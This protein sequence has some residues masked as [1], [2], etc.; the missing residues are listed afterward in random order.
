MARKAAQTN[1]QVE[2]TTDTLWHRRAAQ[3]N[4]QVEILPDNLV[5]DTASVSDSVVSVHLAGR[6][7]DN[8][9]VHDSVDRKLAILRSTTDTPTI[10]DIAEAYNNTNYLNS[11][12]NPYAEPI[13]TLQI[14]FAGLSLFL[15]DRVWG[16]GA[17]FCVYDEQIYEPLIISWGGMA[18]GRI[19]PLSHKSAPGLS[20]AVLYN[21]VPVGGANNFTELFITYNPHFITITVTEFF[22]DNK[23][24]NTHGV[25]IFKGTIEDPFDMSTDEVILSFSDISLELSNQFSHE[26]VDDTTYPSAEV[27]DIGKM[28]P[29]VWGTAKKVPFLGIN[30]AP[31]STLA[32]S[33]DDIDTTI[34]L[35][36]SSGFGTIQ[37]IQIDDEEIT[38]SGVSGNNL[39]G[40][41]R[42]DNPEGHSIGSVVYQINVSCHYAIGQVV[43]DI[44]TVFVW[45]N[46]LNE[47]V[48]QPTNDYTAYTGKAGDKSPLYPDRAIIEFDS[49][50]TPLGGIVSADIDGYIDST[51]GVYTGTGDALIEQPNHI[52]KHIIIDRCGKTDR[53]IDDDT[54]NV[55]DTS[56]SGEF[57]TQA[58]V[59]TEKPNVRELI[60]EIAFQAKSLEFWEAGKHHFVYIPEIDT[61]D[62]TLDAS[63]IDLGRIHVSYTDRVD[64]AN[65]FSATYDKEWSGYA[66]EVDAS[67]AVISATGEYSIADYGT[68]EGEQLALPFLKDSEEAAIV[69]DWVRDNRDYPRLA[70]DTYGGYYLTNVK[71]GQIVNFSMASGELDVNGGEELN[72]ALLRLVDD[73]DK[74]RVIDMVR[75][76][77]GIIKLEV[78]KEAYCV[79]PVLSPSGAVDYG[80]EITI[81]CATSG[82][83]IY[84]TTDG[85]DPD[86]TSTVYSGAISIASSMTIKA[87]AYKTGI[88]PS[89]VSASSYIPWL[90]E[91]AKRISITI[92]NTN[93]DSGLTNFPTLIHLSASSGSDSDDV[94]AIFD[95]LT[96]DANRKKIAVTTSD[97]ETE[98]YVEIE[99]WDDGNEEAWIWVK[100]PTISSSANTTLYIYYDSSQANN[101]TYIGDTGDSPAQ[102]VW[103][104]DF[105]GVWHMAQD[106]TGGANAIKD[107]TSNANHGTGFNMESG[108]LVNGAIG[109]GLDFDGSDEY[110]GVS[111]NSGLE[112]ASLTVECMA[113][114]A[115]F[116]DTGWIAKT[117]AGEGVW[118]NFTEGYL[119]RGE[120]PGNDIHFLIGDGSRNS[121]TILDPPAESWSHVVGT[122][123]GTAKQM[124]IFYN[125]SE[126]F[127]AVTISDQIV[128]TNTGDVYFARADTTYTDIALDEVRI[129]KIA[130]AAAWTKGTYYSNEDDIMTFGNEEIY[131]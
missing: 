9:A 15:C 120:T 66:G 23:G 21:N 61:V 36:D 51:L 46:S 7:Q 124:R 123:D 108:D 42:G 55:T 128:Y 41:V 33:I 12:D 117:E 74:F 35:S 25:R 67:R 86:N 34:P 43:D 119:L 49:R 75:E 110:V 93:V 88:K 31:M 76:S 90:G 107:S 4:V 50:P 101:D 17:G 62:K 73:S 53:E 5:S 122:F 89:A 22:I 10:A 1:V 52:T 99:K 113:Y 2:V 6:P 125:G 71:R 54:Y 127:T 80:Q 97:G 104:D 32:D 45:D 115:T 70:I 18:L 37:T 16:S 83:T 30:T 126:S 26:I 78:I 44:T 109:K 121:K 84:Y 106:P 72:K 27:V 102:S 28:L 116:S 112:P 105:V 100:V 64:I 82:A 47:H 79:T 63:R 103:D 20:S 96:A 56:L 68:L 29:Q 77:D 87:R 111:E 81:T 59:V 19:D 8:V 91:W 131:S 118:D 95:E 58:V 60:N 3:T 94:T 130:R 39:T 114:F 129:S 69:I 65:V 98:C 24:E 13:R 85:T 14:D 57:F 11:I 38:Y 48:T 40:A 92:S